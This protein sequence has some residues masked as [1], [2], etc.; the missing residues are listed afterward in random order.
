MLRRGN[1]ALVFE[2]FL[3]CYS[4]EH[5]HVRVTYYL[6]VMLNQPFKLEVAVFGKR[7]FA[8]EI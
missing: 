2:D 4:E 8:E 3:A 5:I 1:A 7:T 6:V